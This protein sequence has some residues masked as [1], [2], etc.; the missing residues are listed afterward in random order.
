MRRQSDEGEGGKFL[1]AL[2]TSERSV[3]ENTDESHESKLRD[4]T[5]SREVY[6][7]ADAHGARACKHTTNN[8]VR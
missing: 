8:V 4:H 3:A 2:T 6:F 5:R 1:F 7:A